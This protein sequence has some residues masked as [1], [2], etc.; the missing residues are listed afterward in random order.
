MD[1]TSYEAQGQTRPRPMVVTMKGSDGYIARWTEAP[2]PG[3]PGEY[4]GM[5]V[6]DQIREANY[7][8][9]ETLVVKGWVQKESGEG[10]RA[11]WVE[12]QEEALVEVFAE[13]K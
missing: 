11:G 13:V 1:E 7:G 3:S 12:V 6:T 10:A 2:L 4:C 8:V 9:T 5:L